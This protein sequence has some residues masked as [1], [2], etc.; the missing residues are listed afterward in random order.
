V[1]LASA[2]TAAGNLPAVVYQSAMY[3]N[4]VNIGRDQADAL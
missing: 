2:M 4:H 1:T 3:I